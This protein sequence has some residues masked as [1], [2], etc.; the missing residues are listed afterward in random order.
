[1]KINKVSGNIE[2]RKNKGKLDSITVEMP[3]WDKFI[4]DS[5]IS[6]NIPLF[7]LSTFAK[8]ECDIDTSVREAILVFCINTEIHGVGLETELRLLGWNQVAAENEVSFFTFEVSQKNQVFGQIM[9]TGDQFADKLEI[10]F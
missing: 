3:I 2:I 10:S 9:Q 5:S 7:G 1:M 8:D 4:D 6:V